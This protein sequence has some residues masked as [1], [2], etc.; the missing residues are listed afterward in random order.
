MFFGLEENSISLEH[1]S[2]DYAAFGKGAQPLVILPGLSDGFRT[3][4]GQAIPLWFYYRQFAKSFRVYVFSR[5][6]TLA[7][8]CSTREMAKGQNIAL[9]KLDIKQ[10]YIMGL[11]NPMLWAFRREE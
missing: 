2:M 7:K 1:T 3:V 10:P 8:N 9:E 11:N 5:K 6:R 4:K